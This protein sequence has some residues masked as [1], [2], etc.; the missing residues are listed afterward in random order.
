MMSARI[1]SI[2]DDN[3]RVAPAVL[4]K[5][6]AYTINGSGFGTALGMVTLGP[7]PA[8]GTVTNQ[9]NT[10]QAN[11]SDTTITFTGM[12]SGST[13]PSGAAALYIYGPKPLTGPTP[14]LAIGQRTYT[15]K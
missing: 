7:A 11:W 12:S 4:D 13:A 8:T 3:G 2:Q 14:L 10:T 1:T 15:L 9:L 6:A 5:T